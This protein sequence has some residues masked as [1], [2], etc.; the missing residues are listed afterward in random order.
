MGRGAGV[1]R[2]Y[3]P[4]SVGK[5]ILIGATTGVAQLCWLLSTRTSATWV[6]FSGLLLVTA[7]VMGTLNYVLIGG[8]AGAGKARSLLD[9][10]SGKQSSSTAVF[11]WVLMAALAALLWFVLRTP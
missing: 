9:S 5:K 3:N 6:R 2:C 7:I 8:L 1:P 11:F 10:P 4:R